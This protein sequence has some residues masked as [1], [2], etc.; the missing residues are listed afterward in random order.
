MAMSL[1]PQIIGRQTIQA[2]TY[3]VVV[4]S[5]AVQGLI[6]GRLMRSTTK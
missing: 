5:I 3:V 1:G 4:L 2:I 6:F